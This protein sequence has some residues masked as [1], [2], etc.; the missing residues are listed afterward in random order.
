MNS[1]PMMMPILFMLM[2]IAGNQKAAC[3]CSKPIKSP[4]MLKI[5]GVSII[6][7]TMSIINC[8]SWGGAFAV[9]YERHQL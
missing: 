8:C 9:E 7:R 4:L 2:A 1:A 6:R 3:D 5:K